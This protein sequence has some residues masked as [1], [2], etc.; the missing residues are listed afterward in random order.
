MSRSN[1][2][3]K[4]KN[5]RDRPTWLDGGWILETPR[6]QRRRLNAETEKGFDLEYEV[7]LSKKGPKAVFDW[8]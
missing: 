6:Q 4:C 2:A 3:R 1:K 7:Q 5:R 8:P